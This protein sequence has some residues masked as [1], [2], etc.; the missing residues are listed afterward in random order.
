MKLLQICPAAKM[1]SKV[2]KPS[3]MRLRK[4]IKRRKKEHEP[5]L[6][7]KLVCDMLNLVEQVHK[8]VSK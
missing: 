6:K 2:R 8:K 7:L 4:N 3:K 1:T 5:N